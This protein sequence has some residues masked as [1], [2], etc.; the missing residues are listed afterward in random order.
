M[1]STSHYSWYAVFLSSFS[2]SQSATF[3]SVGSN[4]NA[5][6]KESQTPI[7]FIV[8][9]WCCHSGLEYTDFTLYSKRTFQPRIFESVTA[10]DHPSE[11]R[12]VSWIFCHVT[13]GLEILSC[14][15]TV[16]WLRLSTSNRIDGA[17]SLLNLF[18]LY[19]STSPNVFFSTSCSLQVLL[20]THWKLNVKNLSGGSIFVCNFEAYPHG[21]DVFI[22]AVSHWV[23]ET[24]YFL[25]RGASW[26][27][28]SISSC[29]L[30]L[31]GNYLSYMSVWKLCP[32]WLNH[33]VRWTSR[34]V[35]K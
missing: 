21:I 32:F 20:G 22:K 15:S 8:A 28:C 33:D 3:S 25:W 29:D 7:L 10:V 23:D 12:M 18:V 1:L 6:P 17:W 4:W 5:S 26:S 14:L 34:G 35:P 13:P 30:K 11:G 24:I 27:L 16:R 2:I 19:R 9:T 31:S